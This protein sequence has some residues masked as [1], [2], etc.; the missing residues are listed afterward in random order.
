MTFGYLVV[1]PF[2]A[3]AIGRL[4]GH[5][6]PPMNTLEL[7]QVGDRPVYLPHLVLGIGTTLAIAAINYRG[8][9]LSARFQNWA[10]FGLLAVFCVFVSLALWRGRFEQMQPLFARGDDGGGALL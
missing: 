5:I 2:E 1:C 9:R 4:V 3:V 10:T 7:Y 8:I 6:L